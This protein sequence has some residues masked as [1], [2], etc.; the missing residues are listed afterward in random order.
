M[1][2]RSFPNL[3]KLILGTIRDERYHQ[4]PS[5]IACLPHLTTLELQVLCPLSAVA[6]GLGVCGKGLEVLKFTGPSTSRPA[7]KL[8][9]LWRVL[10]KPNLAGVRRLEMPL[11]ATAELKEP[12]GVALLL[13]CDARGISASCRY[14]YV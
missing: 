9:G 3:R 7:D 10:R 4:I 13:E 5:L 11:L 14:G 1:L 8:W 12:A 6:V 2:F